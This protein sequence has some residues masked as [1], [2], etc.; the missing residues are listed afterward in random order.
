MTGPTK[1]GLG[2]R[3]PPVATNT[4]LRQAL[5]KKL[6]VTPQRMSQRVTQIKRLHGPMSTEDATYVLA[7]QEG[8]VELPRFD[9]HLTS[10]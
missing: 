7:H 1:R 9:G 4:K 10:R 3:A 2:Q 8:L 5:L 6:G